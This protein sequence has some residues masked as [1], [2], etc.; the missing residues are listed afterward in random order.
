MNH[1]LCCCDALEPVQSPM[2]RVITSIAEFQLKLHILLA[3][4]EV[5][6]VAPVGVLF[7][8]RVYLN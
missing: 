2:T 5:H 8:I 6:Q 3:V 4:V 7:E 1:Y